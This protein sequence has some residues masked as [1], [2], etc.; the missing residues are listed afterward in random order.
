M[1]T[2]IADKTWTPWKTAPVQFT[3][4]A[5]DGQLFAVVLDV[6]V[7]TVAQGRRSV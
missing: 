5:S 6:P 1:S 4:Y 7:E 3:L 2:V